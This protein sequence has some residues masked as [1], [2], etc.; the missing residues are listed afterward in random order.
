MRSA[1]YSDPVGFETLEIFSETAAINQW[2]FEKFNAL[3]S[4][5]ILEIGS[6][7]VNKT[8]LLIANHE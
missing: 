4:G 8:D 3:I 6:G 7:I 2:T 1:A 5:E